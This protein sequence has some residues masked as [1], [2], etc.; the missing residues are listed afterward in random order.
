MILSIVFMI[1]WYTF[2][3]DGFGEKLRELR[4]EKGFT[5]KRLAQEIGQAQSTVFYWEQNLQE[6]SISALKKICA[7]FDVSADY[8]LGRTDY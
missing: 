3:M 7:V 4:K 6:P 8:L 2:T 5:Q 1:F